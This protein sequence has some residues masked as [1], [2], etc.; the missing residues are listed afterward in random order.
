MDGARAPRLHVATRRPTRRTTWI[1]SYASSSPLQRAPPPAPPPPGRCCGECRDPGGWN[2]ARP[3]PIP[4]SAAHLQPTA[5]QAAPPSPYC[6]RRRHRALLAACGRR[7]A[8]GEPERVQD[9]A[10][11]AFRAGHL[12]RQR[13]VVL[14]VAHPPPSMRLVGRLRPCGAPLSGR[15]VCMQRRPRGN[16]LMSSL[17]PCDLALCACFVHAS[18]SA[19]GGRRSL[20]LTCCGSI[21]W[22]RTS[23]S[24]G[25]IGGTRVAHYGMKPRY[26]HPP[27]SVILW[28]RPTGVRRL[29]IGKR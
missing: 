18:A 5:R 8:P 22:D 10:M 27:P 28:L 9:T 17:F 3:P 25:R 24:T 20:E 29:P 13:S 19:P 4:P 12:G 6:G 1:P 23:R 15:L 14:F 21:P 16:A 7:A 11:S 26:W 2:T